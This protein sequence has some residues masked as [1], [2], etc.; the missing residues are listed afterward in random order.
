MT[1]ANREEMLME[2]LAHVRSKDE[3][4]LVLLVRIVDAEAFSGRVGESCNHVILYYF[5]SFGT[6]IL[7]YFERAAGCILYTIIIIDP[8]ILKSC[9]LRYASYKT[10]GCRLATLSLSTLPKRCS[11]GLCTSL[12][13]SRLHMIWCLGC[14]SRRQLS[15]ATCR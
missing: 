12:L 4:I 13:F 9:R 3:V 1:V 14:T 5:C 8:L 11:C 2:G 15:R 10:L 6:F 7:F